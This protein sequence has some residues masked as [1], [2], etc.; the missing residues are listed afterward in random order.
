[1]E[2]EL[3]LVPF[4]NPPGWKSN[5]D[6]SVIVEQMMSYGIHERWAVI[7]TMSKGLP[8]NK[9]NYRARIVNTSST[10]LARRSI[11]L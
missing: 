1:M 2:Q 4:G 3:A 10:G 11:L 9:G 8:S 5:F 7:R 6:T